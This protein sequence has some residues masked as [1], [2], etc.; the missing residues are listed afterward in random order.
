MNVLALILATLLPVQVQAAANPCGNGSFE[1]LGREGFPVD[2]APIGKADVSRDAHAGQRSLR[3]LRTTEP[4][5]VE[6]GVNARNIDRIRGGIDFYYKAVSARD[7]VL[8]IYAIPIA[9]SGIEKTSAPRAGFT[10]PKEHVGDGQWHHGRLKYDFSKNPAVKSTIIAAR[11]EGTAG[12]LLLDSVSYVDRVGPVLRLG[13]VRLEED[14]DRPG[15]LCTVATTVENAGDATVRGVRLELEAPTGLAAGVPQV[16]VGDLA[17][18]DRKPVL[19]TLTGDR[20]R[21]TRLRLNASGGGERETLSYEVAPNLEIRS[22]GPTSPVGAVGRPV[23]IECILANRGSAAVLGPSAEFAFDGKM[24]VARVDRVPPGRSVVL[25]AS[26]RAG[27]QALA[28]PATVRVSGAGIEGPLN[29]KSSLVVGAATEPPPPSGTLRAAIASV[30]GGAGSAILEN[31]N[32]RLVFRRNEFGFG[33]S[34]VEV[35]TAAGWT[36]AAWMPRLS[37]VVYLDG[38]AVRHD[39]TV[40][41]S[42]EPTAEFAAGQPALRFA[43]SSAGPGKP[44]LHLA[45]T[46]ALA[47]GARTITTRHELTAAAPCGLLALEGPMVYALD[48]DEAVYPGLEWLVNDEVSS[49]TLDIAEG[50]AD[51]VRYVVHPNFITIPALGVHSRHGT[52][53][54]LWDIHQ[55]WDGRRDRPSAVFASPDRFE[56]QRAHLM[57]LFLPTVPGFVKLNTREA[58]RETPFHLEAGKPIRLEAGIYADATAADALAAVDEWTRR[59]GFP[60]PAPLPRG[61]YEREIEFSMRA[62]LDSLWVPE[63][64]EWW[65][66]KGG[67][68]MS[69]K[70][71][72]SGFVADLLLGALLSPDGDVRRRCRARV[73]EVLPLVGG[74]PRLDAQRFPGRRDLAL[75]DPSAAAGLL[76]SREKDGSWRFDAGQ[77]GTGPFVGLDYHVL[78]PDRAAEVG[79]C[80]AK[81]TQVLRYARITGDSDAY[82]QMLP[83]LEFMESFRVPRAAQVWEVPVHAP[84]ILAAAEATEA[85]VEAYRFSGDPRWLRDA[86]AW[87]R[88]GLPFVYLW[89]DPER[90]FLVGAS[91]PV[92]GATWMQGSWFGRPVQWNGLR[93]AEAIL[94]LAKYDQNRPWRELAATLTHSAMHQQEAKGENV[95]LWPDNIGAVDSD[96]CPWVFTPRMIL[97]NLLELI[98]RDEHVRT[99]IVGQGERRIHINASARITAASWDGSTCGFQVSYPVGEQGVVVVF[100]VARPTSV[101]LDGTT[102]A[103]RDDLEGGTQPGWRYLESAACLSIRVVRDGT[104]AIAIAGAGHRQGPRLPRRAETIDFDFE[105]STG[106]WTAAHD[107]SDIRSEHGAL[108]GR[109]TGT[110]PY[111]VRSMLRVRADACPVLVVNMKVSAGQVAKFYWAT[112]SSPGIAED[113]VIA[114]PIRSDGRFHEYRLDLGKN[115]RWAGQTVTSIRL[116]P[117]KNVPSA[118]FAIDSLRAESRAGP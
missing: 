8:H 28:T 69:T 78:G 116:D 24:V 82:R 101:A 25:R 7:V 66:S 10:V 83:T 54:L 100:N 19:W 27:K 46:F 18:D 80:A 85:Y 93:Y 44:A 94:A 104:S 90:P 45:V 32:L 1:A 2:W 68:S 96:K 81:A 4:P 105:G 95:A 13:A 86:V 16:V 91:I 48:R 89:D 5:T 61:S 107:V 11:L 71:R 41:V 30:T 52:V 55:K 15:Q 113:K 108:V 64:R 79:L 72:S 35:K 3:L 36:T 6:T 38:N 63:T 117:V 103:E 112:E 42:E 114:F 50:H 88:R 73:D 56:N 115:S 31:E 53:G 110:D 99:T 51:R 70:E 97:A 47:S 76:A 20:D 21:R 43:W 33:P 67:G 39:E 60:R 102:I 77:V 106:G 26:F 58:A 34:A 49:G 14:P 9:A 62:Y 17:P 29:A 98:G 65:S 75:A 118:D 40:C 84:D 92:F 74:A 22:F 12:E 37:R 59:H 111:L 87:A 57:G 23:V 109:V